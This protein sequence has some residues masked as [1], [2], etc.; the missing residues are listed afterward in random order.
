[1]YAFISY[2][3]AD[4]LVAGKIKI[5]LQ[6]AGINSF[7]AH[8]DVNVSEEWRLKI[9]EEIGIADLFVSLWSK[10]YYSSWWCIQES[11][12]ASFRKDL[13]VVPLSIDGSAPQGFASNIQSTNIDP[14]NVRL[15]DLMPG[16]LKAEPDFGIKIL[17]KN[18]ENSGSFRG[19]ETNLGKIIPYLDSLTPEQGKQLL[20]ISIG[21]NQVHNA[22]LCIKKYLPPIFA[23]HGSLLEPKDHLF[24]SELL[25]FYAA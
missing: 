1:M 15:D 18:I 3:I 16:L 17:L 13:T 6:E 9:L 4:K 14:G 8:E 22:S 12:I 19:A 23:T 7:M 21:N 24:L 20:E 11:G 25:E 2:Q 10:N 5:L